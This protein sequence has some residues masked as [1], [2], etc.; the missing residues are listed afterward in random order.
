MSFTVQPKLIK[1]IRKYGAFD[2]SACFNCGNCTAV[3]PLSDEH[4]SFPRKLIRL[5]QIGSRDRI[6][7]S[8][9]PWLCYYCGECSETCPRQAE[10]GEYMA[11][12]RRYTIAAS[13]PTGVA[14]LMYQSGVMAI[15]FT[16]LVGIVFGALMLS[17]KMGKNPAHWLFTPI[18]YEFIHVFGVI[19][20]V[21]TLLTIFGGVANVWRR[22]MNGAQMPKAK[23][24]HW[25]N[26]LKKTIAEIATMARY[27]KTTEDTV[28]SPWYKQSSWIHMGIMYGFFGLLI[29]TAMDFLFLV[30]L[31]LHLSVFWPS[32]ILG[33]V[34]GLVM[35]WGVSSAI[36]RRI[37]KI[38]KDVEH[39]RLP[40]WWVLIFLFVLGVTGFWLELAVTIKAS[41]AVSDTV[42]LIHA[43]MAMELVLLMAFTKM[44]H[45]IYRPIAIFA[46]YLKKSTEE[47]A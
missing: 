19:V 32:R 20:S 1:E 30:L 46:Y 35:L 38:E 16:L 18:S 13:E 27:R 22:I 36:I 31:P 26:A 28:P 9:E 5:G 14:R 45:V 29:A 2:I 4:G 43:A 3:C 15:L 40:D 41:G 33:T 17:V 8:P 23:A 44:A 24:A 37:T 10:P 12:L 25:M 11:T 21:V 6:L 7:A 34:A 39:S 47:P 42:M